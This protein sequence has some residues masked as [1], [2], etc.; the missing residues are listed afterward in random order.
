M[1]SEARRGVPPL[2]L[3]NAKP[4]ACCDGGICTNGFRVVLAAHRAPVS[5]KLVLKNQG[6]LELNS[7][8]VHYDRWVHTLLFLFIPLSIFGKLPTILFFFKK[9]YILLGL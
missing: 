9:K 5:A 1:H 2:L 4:L 3:F 7:A 6:S 8:Q